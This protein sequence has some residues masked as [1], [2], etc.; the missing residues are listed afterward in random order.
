MARRLGPK[1]AVQS[2]TP[3]PPKGLT[4]GEAKAD[5]MGR[6]EQRDEELRNT[7]RRITRGKPSQGQPARP[8]PKVKKRS[9]TN[10]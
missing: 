3:P 4:H 9:N 5:A 6:Q 2:K 8:T 7:T 10:V 1:T